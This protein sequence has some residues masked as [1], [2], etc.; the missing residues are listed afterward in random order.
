[1]TPGEG[2]EMSNHPKLHPD[3]GQLRESVKG[4]PWKS[5][6]V[7]SLKAFLG[8]WG[9]GE[10][11]NIIGSGLKET[12]IDARNPIAGFFGFEPLHL[13]WVQFNTFDQNTK[14]PS[15]RTVRFGPDDGVLLTLAKVP[16]GNS[17]KW[18]LLARRKYQFGA[19]D[20]FFEFLRGWVP[21]STNEDRGWKLLGR[22]LPGLKDSP[23]VSSIFEQKITSPIWENTADQNN[24]ITRHLIVVTFEEEISQ[25]DL[26]K[27]LTDAKIQTEYPDEPNVNAEFLTSHPLVIPLG[28]AAGMLN[29]YSELNGKDL[30]Q[31]GEDFSVSTWALFLIRWGWQ[32]PH[33]MPEKGNAL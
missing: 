3:W 13:L 22:D 16:D 18:Y 19:K 5:A 8:F 9:W 15:R 32:F 2:E 12:E 29:A 14:K 11:A 21:D 24:K 10:W 25:S 33:L 31:F 6:L 17:F 28:E 30:Y 27:M 20:L 23:L 4:K 26:Q 1:V 7:T